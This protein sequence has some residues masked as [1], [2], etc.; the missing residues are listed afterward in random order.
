MSLIQQW[1]LYVYI[2]F[3]LQVDSSTG[4]GTVEKHFPIKTYKNQVQYCTEL[5]NVNVSYQCQLSE[6]CMD[7]PDFMVLLHCMPT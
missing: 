6:K 5:I 2:Y 7:M 3:N 1:G 4:N